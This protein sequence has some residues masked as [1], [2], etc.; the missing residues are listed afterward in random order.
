M[1]LGGKLSVP[2]I[3]RTVNLTIPPEPG[4][5]QVFH[6]RGLGMPKFKHPDQRGN[7]Y[8]SVEAALPEK[9]TAEEKK[10][11]GQWKSLHQK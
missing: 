2:G 1:L 11:L 10:L 6:L 8:V 5:G 3:D 9:L 7:L 4:N